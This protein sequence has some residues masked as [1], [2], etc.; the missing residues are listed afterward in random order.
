MQTSAPLAQA[1]G[2][3]GGAFS[4]AGRPVTDISGVGGPQ[5]RGDRNNVQHAAQFD[6]GVG[7]P[8]FQGARCA[9]EVDFSTCDVSYGSEADV[10]GGKADVE[11]EGLLSARERTFSRQ[12]QKVRS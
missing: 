10:I 6:R 2:P 11:I 8:Q 5:F 3:S 7:D 12:A 4:W 9:L 1:P